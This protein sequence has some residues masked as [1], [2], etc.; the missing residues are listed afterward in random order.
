[1]TRTNNSQRT[2]SAIVDGA[3]RLSA[4]KGYQQTTIQDSMDGLNQP[5]GRNGGE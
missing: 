4:R 1:M 5:S 3:A 2:I